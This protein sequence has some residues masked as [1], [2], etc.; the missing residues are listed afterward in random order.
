MKIGTLI[1]SLIATLCLIGCSKHG[2]SSPQAKRS[3]ENQAAGAASSTNVVDLFIR[4]SATDGTPLEGKLSL[5]AGAKG[6]V[7]VVFYLHGAGPRTV[8]NPVQYRDAGGQLRVHRYLDLFS[9]GLA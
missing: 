2:S 8:D 5:P 1:V 9:H 6:P 4:F 3:S 7:P